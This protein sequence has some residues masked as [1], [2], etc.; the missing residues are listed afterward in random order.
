[1]ASFRA[2]SDAEPS[3]SDD[4]DA[5]AEPLSSSD[6]DP[7]EV[8]QLHPRP[9]AVYNSIAIHEKLE[10]IAWP[11]SIDWLHSLSVSFDCHGAEVDVNDDLAREMAFYT[12]ALE[13]TRE[14]FAKLQALGIPFLR[15]ADYYAEMVKS[16]GHMLKVK[17]MLL[18]QQKQIEE[19]EERRKAREAKRFSKE[20]Q[21]EKVK[22]RAK[23][24][25]QS[26]EAVKKWRKMRQ[27]KGFKGGEEDA[28][29]VDFG[30][31]DEDGD[32]KAH[33][34]SAF[35]KRKRSESERKETGN[36]GR[37][38]RSPKRVFGA[39][40]GGSGREF[41]NGKVDSNGR[42]P[43]KK[44][45]QV[46]ERDK[47]G[48]NHGNSSNASIAPWDRSGGKGRKAGSK[49]G[50][51]LSK[52]R[53]ARDLKY[54]HGGRKGMKKANTAESSAGFFGSKGGKGDG[55]GRKGKGKKH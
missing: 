43:N 20:V 42:S 27:E 51:N 6:D 26:I 1:M 30:D 5:D 32:G 3:S 7:S 47:K 19:T 22:A 9:N 34:R 44:P 39:P 33:K 17:E 23:E 21:A 4:A 49:I 40:G 29:P 54:G 8:L 16:D 24:K 28:F 10:E 45:F 41:S 18:S 53:K 55:R 14:A 13:G 25:K 50:S 36:P 52:N 35:N 12:Q 15:P 46:S 31:Q 48:K 11:D 38:G 2:S 37:D